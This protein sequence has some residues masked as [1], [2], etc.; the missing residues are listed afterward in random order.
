MPGII[1]VSS[2]KQIILSQRAVYF[3]FFT[4]FY[5]FIQFVN[6]FYI[7]GCGGH[8]VNNFQGCATPVCVTWTH[9]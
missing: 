4:E 3:I 8:T 5:G 1:I 6:K 7:I 2:H 9:V